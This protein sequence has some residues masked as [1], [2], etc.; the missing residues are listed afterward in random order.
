MIIKKVEIENFF[1]Y[2]GIN[3][4][5]FEEGLN[6]ISA[7]NSGGKSHLFNAFHWTFFNKIYVDKEEDSTKKE[8]KDASK[9]ITLP[10]HIKEFGNESDFD[11][12]IRIF[13]SS[14]FH[15]NDDVK[16]EVV[17]YI[18]QKE[19]SFKKRD[20]NS[21]FPTNTPSLEIEYVKNGQTE[22][23]SQGEQEW[24]LDRLFPVSLR[25]FMWF[26]GETVDELYDFGNPSTLN[27][28]IKEISYFPI[29]E[30]FV[31]ITS[32]SNVSINKK[33]DKEL[34]KIKKLS[35]EQ[36][37]IINDIE[38]SRHSVSSLEE[39]IIE[40]SKTMEELNEAIHKEEEKLKGFDKY[41]EIKSKVVQFDY[42]IKK[43]KEKWENLLI[44]R[45]EDFI[46]KWMLYKCDSLIEASQANIDLL[47]YE[48]QNM[49]EDDSPVP[50]TLPGPEYVEK[51]LEDHICYICNRPVE[52]N[53]PAHEALLARM[54]D[55]KN[56]QIQKILSN[57][58]TDLKKIKR[59]VSRTLATISDEVDA[60]D[61]EIVLVRDGIRNTQKKKDNLYS[62]SGISQTSEITIGA[63]TAE[64]LLNKLKNLNSSRETQ[65]RR[66]QNYEID[67]KV[68]KNKIAELIQ[69]KNKLIASQGDDEL[70]EMKA[71]D[72]IEILDNIL[73][74]LKDKAL[75]FL[76]EEIEIESNKLY[77]KYL[78][79]VTQGEIK[80]ER[81]IGI[82]D[83]KTKKV[84][85]N[86][87]TAELTAQKLAVA[88]AF[89]SL[90]EKKMNRS[91]PLLADAP[92]SQ[93]DDENTLSLTKNLKD[94][95]KQ[96]IVM[97]KDYNRIQGRELSNFIEEAKVS[98]FYILKNDMID[99]NGPDSRVNK[100]TYKEEIK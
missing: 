91:F 72:Y 30:N 84:L 16:G 7:K 26:Q 55:F 9:I 81:G 60:N 1:C 61:K 47:S 96:I 76:I 98:K 69:S 13:L 27:Y 20:D 100:K 38:D 23:I 36:E 52:E 70:P 11:T 73:N 99:L 79:G 42:D 82:V 29:Y 53:S 68:E 51:M 77:Q 2:V 3:E 65:S 97:S 4:F 48:V 66:L 94:S 71:K 90:S 83:K 89:L 39:N 54:N 45:K 19:V 22:F 67:L 59:D 86:L 17:D 28:A 85:S 93:F 37:K 25:K 75:N 33:I 64:Q 95:F 8:W 18:F 49:Q 57:N 63:S 15:Q 5:L 24:F 40:T 10:D 80:I 58:L 78:G 34:R 88:N 32:N 50:M 6:I 62:E 74:K 35:T 12:R 41:S 87:N 92:T 44:E 43:M 46:S 56:N 31:R 14:E 21:F